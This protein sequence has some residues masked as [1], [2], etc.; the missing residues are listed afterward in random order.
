MTPSGD[1]EYE[2]IAENKGDKKK[3]AQWKLS[4]TEFI[5]QDG[6]FYKEL[7]SIKVSELLDQIVSNK[8]T[9]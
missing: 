8:K 4:I 7:F 3:K 6:K 5:D 2:L 1:C 9:Q